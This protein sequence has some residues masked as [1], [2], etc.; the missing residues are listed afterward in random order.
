MLIS[1]ARAVY[2]GNTDIYRVYLGDTIVWGLSYITSNNNLGDQGLTVGTVVNKQTAQTQKKTLAQY[3]PGTT[4]FDAVRKYW[5]DWGDDIFDSWGFFYLYDPQ[6]NNYLAL[7]MTD[8]EQPD[9]VISEDQF[10]FNGR[11]F[12]V[13]YGYPAQGIFKIDITVD[14]RNS[15]FVFG[16]DGNLGSDGSTINNILAADYTLNGQDFKLHYN[17]N[18]QGTNPTEKFYTYVV[19]YEPQKNKTTRSYTRYLYSTDNLSI[20]SVPVK[21][22]VTVYISKQADVK[23]WVIND[24]NLDLG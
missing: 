9:G 21:R 16:M 13:N 18:Y 15:D 19:P 6:Q 4:D 2:Y 10:L 7:N 14:D 22:G 17:Y 23:N 1:D 24:L 11:T 3:L 12:T 8:M 5:T 20:H